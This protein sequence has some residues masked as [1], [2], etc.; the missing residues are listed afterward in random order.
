MTLAETGILAGLEEE[1]HEPGLEIIGGL[2]LRM[3]LR[4][5]SIGI[6]VLPRYILNMMFPDR[7]RE[8][9]YAFFDEVVAS[10]EKEAENVTGLADVIEF[11][12]KT[13]TGLF[14][15]VFMNFLP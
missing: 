2:N 5:I 9:I 6:V 13:M 7:A 4:L 12:Q 10:V 11:K 1:I 3:I 8:R 15:K 14:P